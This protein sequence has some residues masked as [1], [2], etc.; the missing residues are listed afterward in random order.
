MVAGGREGANAEAIVGG[1]SASVPEHPTCRA[2]ERARAV[3]GA[4][5]PS[6]STATGWRALRP[7][8]DPA[9]IPLLRSGRVVAVTSPRKHQRRSPHFGRHA[10]GGRN[11]LHQA[12]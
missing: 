1:I 7:T 4:A 5:A 12:P 11:V 6:A 9:Y 10:D 2:E 3:S 8:L